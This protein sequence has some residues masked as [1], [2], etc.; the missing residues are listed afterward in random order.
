ME[1][2][3][4]REIVEWNGRTRTGLVAL[5]AVALVGG[6]EEVVEQRSKIALGAGSDVSLPLAR[7]SGLQEHRTGS[8]K[9]HTTDL[10]E[11]SHS[12]DRTRPSNKKPDC[13][14][15]QSGNSPGVARKNWP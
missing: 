7:L 10:N 12:K 3:G 2:I 1:F 5:D 9:I 4:N 13:I 11:F 8:L 6:N 15:M 14:F